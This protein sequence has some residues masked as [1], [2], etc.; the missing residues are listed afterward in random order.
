MLGSERERHA[1]W[2]ALYKKKW[3][4]Y[5]KR[6]FGGP[7][8][9]LG[10]LANYTHRVAISNRRIIGATKE[11]VTFSWRDYRD[12]SKVKL[13]TLA[14]GEFVRRFCLHILPKGLVRIRHY[15]ILSNNRRKLDIETVRSLLAK[16]RKASRAPA[17][18][19]TMPPEARP[20][21][22]C[23]FC[24]MEGVQWMGFIDRHGV[25]HYRKLPGRALDSP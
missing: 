12:A 7:E 17:P 3:V 15:G 18:P 21:R 8:Q 1:W 2:T 23:P 20:N 4:V 9:V 22:V 6:P 16:R 5:S 14:T 11:S 10:Y 25:M 24:G 13:L 19:Q